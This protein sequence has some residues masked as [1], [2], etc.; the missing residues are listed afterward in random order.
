MSMRN[1][2]LPIL[3]AGFFLFKP[4]AELK[5]QD[6]SNCAS[7]YKDQKSYFLCISKTR[8]LHIIA[9]AVNMQQSELATI[10]RL[11]TKNDSLLNTGDIYDSVSSDISQRL[12]ML[13]LKTETT[14]QQINS[15]TAQIN[16]VNKF[17]KKYLSI[18]RQ[19]G[20]LESEINSK[21]GERQK[22]LTGIEKELTV[23]GF[24]AEKKQ[25][26]AILGAASV[27][28]EK[29][30]QKISVI[31][32]SKDSILNA[33]NI[34]KSTAEQ[35]D[36]RL[37][38]YQKRLDSLTTEI[39]A[40]GKTI[41]SPKKYIR[42]REQVKAKVFLI[43]SVVNKTVSFR[44][45][46]F[47]MLEDGL[48]SSKPS[49]FSLAAFFGPG[50][51]IIPKEKYSLAKKYFSPVV[52]TLIKFSNRYSAVFRISTVIVNGYADATAIMPGSKLYT[53]IS[54]HTNKDNPDKQ[55]LNM[56]LSTL[57]AE[58]LSKFFTRLILERSTEFSS[59]K[60]IVFESIEVGKGEDL[61]DSRI[62][63]YKINDE[64]RRIVIIFWS[65]MPE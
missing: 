54:P 45:F 47:K 10:T 49:M 40:V 53:T 1:Y 35:I 3:F 20:Y 48:S 14:K 64:R 39:I 7:Y 33:G 30:T 56:A 24:G 42:E 61:P 51:Y 23:N 36:S 13:R 58:E 52:D 11:S 55:D 21:A 38:K 43:D 18:A 59:F 37:E 65:V 27:Q 31:D 46:T 44:E 6:S 62:T 60:N 19:V 15:L 34:D 32:N 22:T 41:D 9:T 57:R 28:Q 25:L 26:K 4:A 50:G 5:A 63:D 16:A 8:F 2:L 29:E 12:Q 17:G